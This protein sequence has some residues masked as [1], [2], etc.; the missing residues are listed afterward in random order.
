[1][2]EVEADDSRVKPGANRPPLSSITSCSAVPAWPAIEIVSVLVVV[3]PPQATGT[4]P[5]QISLPTT[6]TVA[7]DPDVTSAVT[8]WV[9]G[10]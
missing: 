5:N 9:E 7:A 3:A 6:L 10:S 4:N 1:M 2:S 8:T